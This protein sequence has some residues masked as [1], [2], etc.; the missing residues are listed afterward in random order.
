MPSQVLMRTFSDG[1]N[2]TVQM[3][4]SYC[5]DPVELARPI[6]QWRRPWNVKTKATRFSSPPLPTCWINCAAL[7]V[8]IAPIAHADMMQ[9][10]KT[11]QLLVLDDMGSERHTPFAEDKLFQIVNYRYEE[12]LPTIVTTL[13][14]PAE[15]DNMRPRIASRLLDSMVVTMMVM[16]GP[17]YRR[18][19]VGGTSAR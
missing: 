19:P 4:G 13:A 12:R 5:W 10:I 16:E 6:W 2:E 1:R 18:R 15:L 11:S 3:V 17:D 8:R 7:S 9:R 14:F